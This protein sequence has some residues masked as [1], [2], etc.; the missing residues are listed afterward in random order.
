MHR[1]NTSQERQTNS[2]RTVLKVRLKWTKK[3]N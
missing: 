3:K 2:P 1:L